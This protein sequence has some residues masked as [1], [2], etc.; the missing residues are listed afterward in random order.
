[1]DG[2]VSVTGLMAR[3]SINSVDCSSFTA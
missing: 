1:M 3:F 2:S